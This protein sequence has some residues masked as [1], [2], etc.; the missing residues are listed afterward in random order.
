MLRGRIERE[1]LALD[2]S[3]ARSPRTATA[4]STTSAN[5]S[6]FAMFGRVESMVVRPWPR[7]QRARLSCS[8]EMSSM[9]T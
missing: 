2:S 6:A 8:I 4:P 5:D 3:G 1:H 7:A 9:L